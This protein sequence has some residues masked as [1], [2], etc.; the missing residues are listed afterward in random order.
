MGAASK[1][2][3]TAVTLTIALA[4]LFATG[5]A[6]AD[7]QQTSE[8]LD[9]APGPAYAMVDGKVTKID[10]DVYTVESGG[11]A[12]LDNGIKPTEMRIYVGKQTQK[13]KGEK[14][15]GDKIRAEVTRGGFANF[16]Q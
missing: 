7:P 16:I 1:P 8:Q 13:M 9:M 11:A 10:G 12:Y 4:E 3:M 15:V 6:S 14:K 5:T 2:R